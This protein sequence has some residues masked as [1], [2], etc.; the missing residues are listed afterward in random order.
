MS[1]PRTQGPYGPAGASRSHRPH[2]RGRCS[3]TH[4]PCRRSRCSRPRGT[5]RRGRCSWSHGTC[6]R[7]RCSRPRGTHRRG[8]ITRPCRTYRCGGY[9]RSHRSHWCD[10]NTR[11]YG[12]YRS[13]RRARGG[14]LSALCTDRCGSGGRRQPGCAVW[15][16][17]PGTGGGPTRW[18][19][20]HPARRISCYRAVGR[21]YARTDHTGGRRSCHSAPGAGGPVF[22]QRDK[23]YL[24]RTHDD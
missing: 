21:E 9:S 17:C 8:W 19:C 5:H 4:G 13:H 20:A 10:G 15:D 23:Q 18:F 24:G 1:G 16:H 14:S 22:G 12:P 2:R 11:S 7:S 6:R 3:R